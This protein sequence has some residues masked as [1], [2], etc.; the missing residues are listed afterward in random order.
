MN[1]CFICREYGTSLRGGGIASYIKE[2]AHGLSRLG[3]QITVICASDNTNIE[4]TYYDD[5]IKII[6][7]K[8]GDFIIPQVENK[9]ILLKKFRF[10]Y[11]Y[12]RYRKRLVEIIQRL[13]DID[14]IEVPE[15][16]SEG[17][18]LN[19]LN[20]PVVIRLHT[21]ALLD[22][23]NFKIQRINKTNFIYYN[24]GITEIKLINKANYI[25][26]CS[27]SLKLWAIKY[28]K[29][30]PEKIRVIYN[31]IET[32]LWA[33]YK[34]TELHNNIKLILFAG[35]VC[36]WKGCEDLIEACKILYKETNIKF[37]LEFI[38]KTGIYANKLKQDNK[39]NNWLN[40]IGKISREELMKKY[41]TAD[42]ICFPS[43]WE[44]M[45]M[46]CIEAMLCGG[47]V[48]GSNSGGMKE[49]ITNGKDG[50]LISP[51]NPLMLADTIKKVLNLSDR[52]KEVISLNAQQKIKNKFS[53]EVITHD[54]LQYYNDVINDFK[55]NTK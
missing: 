16:G 15:Y 43:W 29:V 11:R 30:P 10:I 46:V 17:L 51:H 55:K 1:I 48:I 9:H 28:A 21:P 6:S 23:Y 32:Q 36:D 3:H 33:K 19:Q 34:R 38:G 22:H 47:L 20:L 26:S 5:G 49:I 25:S 50:F 4:K 24:H 40:I 13:K 44:N 2:I 42:V 31:P 52:E 37:R 27:E 39:E 14:I 45:P 18:Y 41:T 8:G 35:T 7:L 12:K 54:L 53:M